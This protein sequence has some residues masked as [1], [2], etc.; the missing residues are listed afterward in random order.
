MGEI[1]SWRKKGN[2]AFTKAMALPFRYELR[3]TPSKII[4]Y[5]LF[6]FEMES[7]HA[8][9]QQPRGEDQQVP[10]SD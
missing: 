6:C 1:E 7:T 5:T 4:T 3:L 10:D 9:N 2:G 8:A